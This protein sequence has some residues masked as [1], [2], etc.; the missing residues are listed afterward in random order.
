M[1]NNHE[2]MISGRRIVLTGGTTGIGREIALKL[3]K[4]GA[5]IL[6]AGH[7]DQHLNDTLKA[8]DKSEQNGALNGI[9]ADMGTE[10]GIKA[11]FAKVDELFG[12][13]IDVLIN[14]AAI[15]YGSVTE[16]SYSDWKKVIDTNLLGY[17]ATT[18][19]ALDRMQNV[20]APV[21]IHVGSMSADIREQG[22]SIYVATKAG[23]QGFSESL[24][25]E[26]NERGVRVTLIEPGAVST[27]M[28]P[29]DDPEKQK[30]IDNHE[31][32]HSADIAQSVVYT[33][34]QHERCDVVEIRLRP[35]LQLI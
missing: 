25:K 16:G 29:K 20:E 28:Q 26:V 2:Q 31:M 27:N 35:R 17:I 14:N 11:L 5:N 32:L 33:L 10:E 30:A 34:T 7:D 1:N 19:E 15:A 24:R 8:L 6:I 12:G 9:A 18:R 13:K 23:I 21:I 4:L 22:S 3:A